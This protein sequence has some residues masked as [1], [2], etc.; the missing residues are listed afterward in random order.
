M[1]ALIAPGNYIASLE[2]GTNTEITT[3]GT[4][5]QITSTSTNCEG[6]YIVAHLSNTGVVYYG[7][8]NV[9]AATK[10]GVPLQPGEKDFIPCKDAS[11]VWV[12][13]TVSGDDIFFIP[14]R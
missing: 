4:H 3:S 14:I 2:G 7:G 10:L 8:T 11:I 9:D 13:S 12:D 5:V 6:V 1:L